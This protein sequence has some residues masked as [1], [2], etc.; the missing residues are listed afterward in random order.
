MKKR[1]AR[2]LLALSAL[3]L[4]LMSCN[5]TDATTG[6]SETSTPGATA[7]PSTS[8]S[9]TVTPTPTTLSSAHSLTLQFAGPSVSSSTV[10]AAWL[11]DESGACI[12]NIYVCNRLLPA[13]T[14]TSSLT[15]IAIPNWRLNKYTQNNTVDGVT[16][17]S[18]QGTA[19][20]SVT[21]S[22]SI[23]SARKFR[24]YFEI[25]RSWNDNTYFSDRPSFIY[26]SGLIDL[27]NLQS[28]YA[29]SLYGWMSNDTGSSAGT[30]SQE[31]LSNIS[32]WAKE[33]LMTDLSYIAPT[34]DMVSSLSVTVTN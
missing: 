28:S 30:L 22:L 13:I 7:L 32:G 23:G 21:R 33:T 25:D 26:R 34:N 12:Q 1:S 9:A 3:V 29:L 14:D 5:G 18:V 19:G 8:T 11:E 15:G 4:S 16:G 27:D 2:A 17:A 31:P 10:Y 20:L 6:A 24:A